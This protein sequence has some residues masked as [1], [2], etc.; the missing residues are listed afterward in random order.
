[1]E[2]KKII[3]AESKESK[4][5]MW[6]GAQRLMNKPNN[7]QEVKERNLILLTARVLGV[8]PFGIN[9]L[10]NMP[11]INKL[12]LTQKAKEYAKNI[13]FK[14]QW[15]K[16]ANDD[17]EKAICACKIMDGNKEL[18]DW[19]VGECSPSTQKMSTLKGY[20]NHMAQTR[21]RNRAILE[22]FG[23]QIHEEM[24]LNIQKLYTKKEITEKDVEKIGNSVS[25]SA[26]EINTDESTKTT[27]S[28]FSEEKDIEELYAL[29]R[30]HGA[31][32]GA[33]KQFIEDKIG[34]KLDLNHPTKKYI[35][36]IK[37]QFL[38]KIVK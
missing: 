12:G 18:T 35:S 33:E 28:L 26:E 22:A 38:S 13:Q 15:I 30:E 31:K 3:K 34:H 10:G 1:M 32:V 8:S 20:Q 24:M 25:T 27:K 29:A 23:T 11:Y 9:I 5:A 36:V 16:Y 7:Q 21:A 37:A 6:L 19:V 17:T 2:N 14:Y 4:K